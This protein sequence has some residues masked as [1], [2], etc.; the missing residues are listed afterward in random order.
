MKIKIIPEKIW[1]KDI[2][3]K[4]KPITKWF[5]KF[6]DKIFSSFQKPDLEEGK[7]GE[8]EYDEDSKF[9][10]QSED[11]LTIFYNITPSKKNKDILDKLDEIDKKLEFLIDIVN[12][13]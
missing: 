13:K 7:E 4:G 1:S 2:D 3:I 11:G 5:V 10:K 6:E 8:I 9:E 12:K